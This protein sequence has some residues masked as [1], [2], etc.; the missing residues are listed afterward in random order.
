MENIGKKKPK[1]LAMVFCQGGSRAKHKVQ[2]AGIT[3]DCREA[4]ANYPEG[5][6]ECDRGC[7]GLGSCISVC[8]FGAIYVSQYGTAEVDREKCTGCGACVKVCPKELIHLILPENTIMPRCSNQDPGPAARN[9]C[10]VSCIACRICEKNCPADAV[11]VIDQCAV[12]DRDLC[13]A[14]GMCTIKC[15]RHV[16]V[17]ADGIFTVRAQKAD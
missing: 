8:K 13:I 1:R 3:V 16:I 17:D 7:L 12:I 10:S 14:C 15:P 2:T 5:I 6:L 9:V 4:A 11:R